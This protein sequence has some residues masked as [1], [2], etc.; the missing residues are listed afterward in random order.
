VS[1]ALS[2]LPAQGMEGMRDP[3]RHRRFPGMSCS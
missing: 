2:H 3:D 1:D